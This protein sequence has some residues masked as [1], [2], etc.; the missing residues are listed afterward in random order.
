LNGRS[1][2]KTI[3]D[4]HRIRGRIITGVGETDLNL[5][6]AILASK[7]CGIASKQ[8]LGRPRGGA[9]DFKI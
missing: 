4:G 2:I 8:Q 9:D 3:P 7:L 6:D 5:D 1:F